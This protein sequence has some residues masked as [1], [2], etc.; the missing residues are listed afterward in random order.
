MRSHAFPPILQLASLSLAHTAITT[1][2][3][4]AIIMMME[5]V[6]VMMMIAT[7]SFC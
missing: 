4:V 1:L 6:M 3:Q 7:Y 5:M 2:A